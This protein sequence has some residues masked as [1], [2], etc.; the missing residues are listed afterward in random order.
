MTIFTECANFCQPKK[1]HAHKEVL[2]HM[3]F[4]VSIRTILRADYIKYKL[5]RRSFTVNLGAKVLH[6]LIYIRKNIESSFEK[7]FEMQLKEKKS[8]VTVVIYGV[9]W[10]N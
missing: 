3:F 5:H 9:F 8:S 4:N 2:S 7:C 10:H 1:K 6:Q